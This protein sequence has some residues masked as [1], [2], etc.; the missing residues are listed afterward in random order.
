MRIRVSIL[1]SL[2]F[3]TLTTLF[4]CKNIFKWNKDIWIIVQLF[5]VPLVGPM[6]Y[7]I[8]HMRRMSVREKKKCVTQRFWNTFQYYARFIVTKL[9]AYYIFLYG[10]RYFHFIIYSLDQSR[11][12]G[13]CT[14]WRFRYWSL[15]KNGLELNIVAKVAKLSITP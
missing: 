14:S 6:L 3:F 2:S 7:G 8:W 13:Y 12:L 10:I 15:T 5:T 1:K 4:N 11:L 9:S